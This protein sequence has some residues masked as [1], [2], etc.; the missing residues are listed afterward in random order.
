MAQLMGDWRQQVW[1]RQVAIRVIEILERIGRKTSV[2][3]LLQE[4][5]PRYRGPHELKRD[6]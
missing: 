5:R 3:A 4:R 6:L 2:Q 1:R